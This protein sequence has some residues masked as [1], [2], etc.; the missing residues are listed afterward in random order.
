MTK[1]RKVIFYIVILRIVYLDVQNDRFSQNPK[2]K[3]FDGSGG[4]GVGWVKVV[5]HPYLRVYLYKFMCLFTER[6]LIP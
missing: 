4:E 3:G 2:C 6:V 1:L 5:V